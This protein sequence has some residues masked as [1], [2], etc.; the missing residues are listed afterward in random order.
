MQETEKS[1]QTTT[2]NPDSWHQREVH[3]LTK[4]HAVDPEHG[5]QPAEVA[6]RM[7]VH[8][9]NESVTV[10]KHTSALPGTADNALGDRLNMA[11]KSTVA[12]HGRARGLVVATGRATELGKVA[13]LPNQEDRSTPLQRRLAAFGKRLALVVIG[14]CVV[15]FVA[16]G[17]LGAAGTGRATHGGRACTGAAFAL[18]GNPGL[19]HHHLL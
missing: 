3:E 15:I 2:A 17:G 18:G 14:I 13:K 6:R 9:P 7:D 4:E 1:P 12:T 16:G 19:G 10:A 11:F 8:G 5:L